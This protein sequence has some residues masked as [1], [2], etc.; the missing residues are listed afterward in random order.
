MRMGFSP[1]AK[2]W[3][4]HARLLGSQLGRDLRLDWSARMPKKMFPH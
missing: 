2:K 4:F 3:D 1:F